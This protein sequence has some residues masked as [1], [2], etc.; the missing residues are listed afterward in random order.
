MPLDAR[1]LIEGH[2]AG[3]ALLGPQPSLS[4][5]AEARDLLECDDHLAKGGVGHGLA[6]VAR[7]DAADVLGVLESGAREDAQQVPSLIK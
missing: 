3:G 5:G 2:A 1:L 7:R 6:G 4:L